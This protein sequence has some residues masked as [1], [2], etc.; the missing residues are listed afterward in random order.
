MP[1]S[2]I[3]RSAAIRRASG[4]AKIRDSSMLL[5][6]GAGAAAFTGPAETG[7]GAGSTGDFAS[8][9]TDG[10]GAANDNF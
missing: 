6:R 9:A 1:S 4:L 10:T 3:F 2:A 7:T 5:T 8:L